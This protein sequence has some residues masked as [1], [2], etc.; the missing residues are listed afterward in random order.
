M[1]QTDALKS[2]ATLLEFLWRNLR[3]PRRAIRYLL[4]LYSPTELEAKLR[5]SPSQVVQEL[6]KDWRGDIPSQ[7]PLFPAQASADSYFT[8]GEEIYPSSFHDLYD[9]PWVLY[10]QGDLSLLKHPGPRIAV[11]G[12]R[13]ASDYAKRVTAQLVVGLKPYNPLIVSGMAW[14]IDGIAHQT[15]LDEG[16]ATVGILGAPF[17]QA[18]ASSRQKLFARMAHSALLLTELYPEAT[19]APWRFPERNRLLAA[20]AEAIVVVEAPIPSGALI[21]ARE[22]LELGREIF[23]V[24][25]PLKPHF[26]EG[27]HRLIQEGAHLLIEPREIGQVLGYKILPSAA[28]EEKNGGGD[29][30][31]SERGEREKNP[32]PLDE[33]ILGALQG[34]PLHVDKIIAFSQNPAPAVLAR[35][36]ELSLTGSLVEGAP[37]Y[38]EINK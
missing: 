26:N 4:Y 11:V 10:A 1:F 17:H 23:V 18:F 29:E 14:G 31:F 35:L 9:P 28:A 25:G 7:L 27:G 21:T 15:A 34:G 16:M 2:S 32:D 20:L 38:F 5:H 36:V 24:P 33:S 37:G 12:T 13:R 3:L 8:L 22:G 6:P 19:M 30:G